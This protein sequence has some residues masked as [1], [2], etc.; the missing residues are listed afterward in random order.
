MTINRGAFGCVAAVTTCILVMSPDA[1]AAGDSAPH[2]QDVAA[3]DSLVFLGDSLLAGFSSGGLVETV[4]RSNVPARVAAA[5]AA[6]GAAVGPLEQ[7]LVSEPGLPALLGLVSSAPLVIAPRP[8]TGSALNDDLDRPFDNLSVPG[9]RI[10]DAI[11]TT[12]GSPLIDLALRGRGTTLDQALEL[13]AALAIVWL[14]NNDALGALTSGVVIEGVTLTSVAQFRA[15]LRQLVSSL[16]DSG[17]EVVL[18][19][20]PHFDAIPFVTLLPPTGHRRSVDLSLG[21]GDQEALRGT[22]VDESA[23]FSPC[24]ARISLR[25]DRSR[26]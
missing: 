4:Q 17:V 2:V 7:P 13:D 25:R 22:R 3:I 20:I 10:G 16:A 18:L 1:W 19:E 23:Y 11:R 8:G 14:G 5:L 6:A 26:V 15:D 24:C 9:F 21:S 12:S